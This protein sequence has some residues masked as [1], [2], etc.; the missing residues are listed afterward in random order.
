MSND[1]L[2]QSMG[3]GLQI[4]ENANWWRV[5]G[6]TIQNAKD[7][8]V[9]NGGSNNIIEQVVSRWNADSGIQLHDTAAH[10]LVLNCDSYENYDPQNRGE[11]ADG[12]AVK[13]PDIGPGNIFRGNRAW[14]NS[15]DG[16]DM[17]EASSNGV[18][19]DNSWAFAN[20]HDPDSEN[21]M[22]FRGDGNGYKLGHDSGSHLLVRV[23]AWDHPAHG[24]DINGNGYKYDTQGEPTEPNGNLSRVLNSTA[25]NNGLEG[26]ANFYFDENLA[27]VMRNNVSM[28]GG[29]LVALN[30]IQQL[31]TWNNI[32][33]DA[34]DF[35]T[36]DDARSR[37]PRQADG[38]LPFS[39]FLRLKLD[40]NLVDIGSPYFYSFAG[41]SYALQY[42]GIAPDLGAFEG[43]SVIPLPAGDYNGDFVVDAADYTVW[44]NM[45]GDNGPDL[46]ADGDGDGDVDDDDYTVWKENFGATEGSGSSA[47]I[48]TGATAS[49]PEPGSWLIASAFLIMLPLRRAAPR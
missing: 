16:W 41:K 42:E 35:L 32:P 38:S 49:V 31:N 18:M 43:G 26:G 30:V 5:K 19:I 14:N 27:H 46:A 7:N 13:D 2:G 22:P 39:D 25:Y 48:A 33:V 45:A 40:S 10:N 28:S 34:A 8:G 9:Y 44:R 4:N 29:V 15:D 17:F 11:N 23:A 21:P 36:L 12:F 6:L 24:I 47:A 20:G 3:R 1:L 37:G